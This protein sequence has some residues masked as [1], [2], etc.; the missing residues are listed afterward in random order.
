MVV[1]FKKKYGYAGRSIILFHIIQPPTFN[2]IFNPHFQ[3]KGFMMTTL[4]FDI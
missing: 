4:N 2:I 3:L 1:Q